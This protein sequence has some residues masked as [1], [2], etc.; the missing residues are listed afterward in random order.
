MAE[1]TAAIVPLS[2]LD[3]VGPKEIADRLNVKIGTVYQWPHRESARM[4]EPEARVSGI[5]LW[6]WET[7]RAWAADSNRL[8]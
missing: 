4:P 7:I 8:Y 2:T 3:I 1:K 6:N 5:P